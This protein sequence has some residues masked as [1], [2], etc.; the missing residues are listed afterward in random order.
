M[1]LISLILCLSLIAY[2]FAGYPILMAVL[3]R[4]RQRPWQGQHEHAR[5][6]GGL[7][8]VICVHNAESMIRGRL[9]NLLAC[10]WTAPLEIIVVCDGCTDGTVAQIKR[11]A[12]PQI[13]LLETERI[14][15]KPAGLNM[16]IPQC[17]HPIVVL[18]DVRQNF[19]AD[20]LH[21]LVAPFADASVGAVSGL[22][23]IAS[24]KGGGGSGMDLY[25]RLETRLRAWEG[26]YDSVI[27]CTGAI[28]ALRRDLYTAL[29]EDTLLDDVVIP[30]RIA[31]SGKRVIYEPAARAFDPQK[32][33]PEKEKKRKLR[34]LAGNFQMIE[35]Y[36]VWMLPWRNRLWWQ[37]ISHKYLRLL[38]PWLM[39]AVLALS[40]A[41]SEH[42]ITRLLLV[43]QSGCYILGV[44]GWMV[45]GCRSRFVTVPAGFLMLQ[46]SCFMAFFA[47]LGHRNH[48]QQLWMPATNSAP[49]AAS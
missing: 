42:W 29:P 27:G 22:L 33:E 37:L 45:P 26:R 11:L 4:F 5:R 6:D 16:A 18:A 21:K 20:A 38:V 32:L 28:C 24:S 7:S 19:A 15:G 8:V 35:R 14:G 13:R 36:P 3:A 12:A 34:T 2:S 1:I 30:M 10:S 23:E 39:I 44:L 43:L 25:W 40:L 41:A 48:L 31:H 17:L 47:Y 49:S 9:E 46:A